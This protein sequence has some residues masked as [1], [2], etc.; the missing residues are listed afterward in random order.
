MGPRLP[1][2]RSLMQ[3]PDSLLYCY[4]RSFR[5]KVMLT[6]IRYR[7]S[8]LPMSLQQYQ[9][10]INILIML[11]ARLPGKMRLKYKSLTVNLFDVRAPRSCC[12]R[13]S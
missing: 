6:R 3:P 5:K 13:D 2:D 7:S 9:R 10:V 4:L 12:R 1:W 11:F 8:A